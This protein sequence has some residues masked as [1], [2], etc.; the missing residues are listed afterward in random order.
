M[1]WLVVLAIGYMAMAIDYWQLAISYLPMVM[2]MAIGKGLLVTRLWLLTIW[3]GIG[4]DKF[5][6][7]LNV[8]FLGF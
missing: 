8:W 5:Y 6:V 4:L 7:G 2:A 3:V 1:L